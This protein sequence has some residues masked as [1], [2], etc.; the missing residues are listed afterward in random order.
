MKRRAGVR[1]RRRVRVSLGDAV[2]FTNDI[3][4]GGFSVQMMRAV[5][6][7]SPVRGTLYLG[8]PG[9]DYVGEVVWV[10]PGDPRINLRAS[11]GVRITDP[12]GDARRL[13]EAAIL[14]S[15][16]KPAS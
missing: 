11:V 9:I 4:S 13:I 16:G 5:A 7:G 8:E 3:G 14:A 1:Q 15:K 12:S 6:R 10:K 2:V